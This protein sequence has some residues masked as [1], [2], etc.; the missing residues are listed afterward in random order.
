MS[1]PSGY[2]EGAWQH[3]ASGDRLAY[4][5]WRPD[6]PQTLLVLIHGY[7]EHG[8][9][10]HALAEALGQQGICVAA[11]DLPG[12]GRSSGGRGDIVSVSRCIDRIAEMTQE[13]FLPAA[14]RTEYALFGHSFGGLAALSWAL[15]APR[16]MTK[17]VAQS[18]LIE[19]GF[20]IP[21]WKRAAGHVL[22]RLYP[23]CS[24]ETDLDPAWISHDP[25]VVAAYRT[26]PLVHHRMSAR[27][28]RSIVETRDELARGAASFR[29]PL[30]LLY[31]T[32][33]RIISAPAAQHWF[34]RLAGEKQCAVFPGAYHELHHEPVHGEAVRQ[35][36]EWLQRP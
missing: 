20:P 29:V 16:G 8:G 32:A 10:Y 17:V 33:D 25:A 24:L 12:H 4:R 11:P 5:L 35:I 19:V 21:A 3:A 18:P 2:R 31:G 6:A 9:R 14:G 26:D 23:S 15:R 27:S 1:E 28:Y 34:D 22:A 13:L 30:L 36:T 7:G